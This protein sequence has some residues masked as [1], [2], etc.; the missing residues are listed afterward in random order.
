MCRSVPDVHLVPGRSSVTSRPPAAQVQ[1]QQRCGGR[2][3]FEPLVLSATDD[4]SLDANVA[5]ASAWVD[6]PDAGEEEQQ[7]VGKG[8]FNLAYEKVSRKRPCL[9]QGTGHE[10]RQMRCG[11]G[12][13]APMVRAH[14]AIVTQNGLRVGRQRAPV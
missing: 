3:R 12:Q 6:I 11:A 8:A 4:A 10:E 2:L 5:A 14:P 9:L 7:L 1:Q 13:V